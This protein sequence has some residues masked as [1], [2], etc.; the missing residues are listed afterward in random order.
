VSL[1]LLNEIAAESMI[2]GRKGKERV[3]EEEE[4]GRKIIEEGKK[5]GRDK[6]MEERT[7]KYGKNQGRGKEK[8]CEE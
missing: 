8:R 7:E 6:R 1:F 5:K 3:K 2:R 4:K